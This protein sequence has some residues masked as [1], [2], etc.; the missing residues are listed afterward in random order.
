MKI[1][2]LG[3]QG[4]LGQELVGV[5]ARRGHEVVAWTRAMGDVTNSSTMY[6]LCEHRP[7]VVINAIAYNMVDAAESEE[8][9]RQ[10]EA[11]N[12]TFPALLAATLPACG[13][14]LVHISTDYVFGGTEDMLFTEDDVPSPVNAYGKSKLLGEEAVRVA[15]PQAIIVR[16][17]RLFGPPSA[18][19]NAKKTFIQAI[20]AKAEVDGKLSLVTNETSGPTY[21][22]DL[23]EAILQLIEE[24]AA[25]GMYHLCNEGQASWYDFGVEVLRLLGKTYPIEAI[26]NE[27]YIRPASRPVFSTLANTKRPKLPHWKEALARFIGQA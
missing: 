8:G 5:A 26:T 7:D 25:P 1:V 13:T 15:D 6:A 27:G 22:L 9:W 18:S 20:V 16:S 21:T 11:L 14:R 12:A 17:S 2:V 10:A 19:P 3:A 23:A 4:L 24:Q